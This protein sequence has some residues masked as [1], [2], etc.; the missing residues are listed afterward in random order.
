MKT[1]IRLDSRTRRRG[2]FDPLFKFLSFPFSLALSSRSA[3]IAYTENN[4][5]EGA[6]QE[7]DG[8]LWREDEKVL[9]LSPNFEHVFP[10]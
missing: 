9:K 3:E 7:L 2:P 1:R 5:H 8:A 10:A 4:R 6:T